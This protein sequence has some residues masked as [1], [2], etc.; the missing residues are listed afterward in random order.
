MKDRSHNHNKGMS[1]AKGP[2]AIIGLVLLA[3]AIVAF[4]LGGDEFNASPG[5]GTVNG[6]TFLGIETNGWTNVLLAAAG[7]VLLFGSPF[8][9][10]AKT[11][12]MI[13]GLVLGAASVIAMF[14]GSDVFGIFAA[15]GPTMLLLGAAATALL[16]LSL[17]PRVGRDKHRRDTGDRELVR[18]RRVEREPATTERDPVTDRDRVTSSTERDAR[19]TREPIREDRP[20]E[21]R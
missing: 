4:I 7:L 2:V 8:H 9:W 19:F 20:V 13:V 1:L 18:E 17:L 16:V 5:D 12:A 6:E 14:D 15:N 3:Y 10:G 11:T 21:R